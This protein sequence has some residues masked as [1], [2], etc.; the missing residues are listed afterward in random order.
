MLISKKIEKIKKNFV[1][2]FQSLRQFSLKFN[3]P[4]A[5]SKQLTKI[6]EKIEKIK[7]NSVDFFQR[8]EAIFSQI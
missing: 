6:T 4:Q 3:Y 2:F 1:D 8:F 7:K 5:I